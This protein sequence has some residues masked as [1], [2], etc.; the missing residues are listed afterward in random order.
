MSGLADDNVLR[1]N[2]SEFVEEGGCRDIW[3][4]RGIV[5]V[6]DVRWRWT[7]SCPAAGIMYDTI[8]LCGSSFLL[9]AGARQC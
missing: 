2:T 5:C 7:A 9:I 4:L 6:A 8:W 3:S 1:A